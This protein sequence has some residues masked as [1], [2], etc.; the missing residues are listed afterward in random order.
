M[1]QFTEFY[2]VEVNK[3]GEES[4]L[5]QN[6]SN[7]FV[8]GASPANAYKF[9]DEEQVKKVCAIQNMLAG[10]FNNGTKTYYVKQEVTRTKYNQD[11]TVYE[12][13]AEEPSSREETE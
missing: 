6:Y 2:L 3:N 9:K 12:E 7:S 1:E 10:I 13:T 4:A 8:R 5:M 11:G